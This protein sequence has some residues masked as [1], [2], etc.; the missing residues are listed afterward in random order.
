MTEFIAA[1]PKL[2]FLFFG[3][4]GGV[5]KTVMAGVT[6]LHLAQEGKRTHA[7]LHQPGAQPERAAGP[8]RLRTAHGR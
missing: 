2:K 4:K 8:E 1:H 7:G 6:A 3:G 5:G